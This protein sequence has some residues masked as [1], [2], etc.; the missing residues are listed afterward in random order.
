[1]RINPG[2]NS[3]QI[4][5]I[6]DPAL[7]LQAVLSLD[8]EEKVRREREHRMPLESQGKVT[9]ESLSNR[10]VVYELVGVV[11]EIRT[12]NEPPHLVAHVRGIE[13]FFSICWKCLPDHSVLLFLEFS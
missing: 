12:P 3:L 5:E 9:E 8:E 13:L 11:A 2:D 1:M 10:H 6:K 7:A 4:T